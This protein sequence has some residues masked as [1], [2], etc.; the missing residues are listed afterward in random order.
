MNHERI[1]YLVDSKRGLIWCRVDDAAFSLEGN[2]KEDPTHY[3]NVL[4]GIFYMRE[5]P[6]SASKLFLKFKN[7]YYG[8]TDEKDIDDFNES[9]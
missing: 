8:T 5:Y 9:F 1:S 6:E 2:V 7:D 4:K 3:F